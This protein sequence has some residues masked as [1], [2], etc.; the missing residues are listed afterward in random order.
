MSG[1]LGAGVAAASAGLYDVGYILEKRA[2]IG[3]PPIE[4]RPRAIFGLAAR[5][6]LWAAGFA[7]MLGGLGLQVL[8][9]TLAPVSVVQPILAGG[10]IALAA[11]GSA[12]LGERLDNRHRMALLLILAAV[13]AVAASARGGDDLAVTVSAGRFAAAAGVGLLVVGVLMGLVPGG[14]R[15][16]LLNT[17]CA[18]GSV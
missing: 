6:P 5:S 7:T 14:R 18:A 8:A 15:R 11:A 17:A 10:L 16:G 12:V 2:L 3:L 4:M 1:L 13:V 9:L